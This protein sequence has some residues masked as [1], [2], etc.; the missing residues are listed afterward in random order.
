[1]SRN[2]L[3]AEVLEAEPQALLGRVRYR[4]GLRVRPPRPRSA[5]FKSSGLPIAPT[6][7]R[8]DSRDT[9]GA[10]RNGSLQILVAGDSGGQQRWG[11]AALLPHPPAVTT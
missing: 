10:D 11:G 5:W 7:P 1:M 2:S 3:L 4:L 6:A 8:A 9:Y